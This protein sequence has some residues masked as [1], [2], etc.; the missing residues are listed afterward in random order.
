MGARKPNGSTTKAAKLAPVPQASAAQSLGQADVGPP[1]QLERTMRKHSYST[2]QI[3]RVA[4][5]SVT[6]PSTTEPFRIVRRFSVT[7]LPDLFWLRSTVNRGQRMVSVSELSA[8]S[9]DRSDNMSVTL[10][11]PTQPMGEL[12]WAA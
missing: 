5:Q 4:S 6:G 1:S 12:A 10:P 8:V 7:N 2:G 11:V 3:V 9:P